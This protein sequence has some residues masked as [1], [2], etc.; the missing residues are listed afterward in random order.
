MTA[1]WDWPQTELRGIVEILCSNRV[2][3]LLEYAKKRRLQLN[4]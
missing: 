2:H 3:D 4:S 1:W